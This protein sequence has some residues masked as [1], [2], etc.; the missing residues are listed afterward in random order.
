MQLPVPIRQENFL[1]PTFDQTLKAIFISGESGEMQRRG[2]VVEGVVV[3][4]G[5]V[6]DQ[7][8]EASAKKITSIVGLG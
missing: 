8:L 3:D 5:V 2:P 4:V 7:G 6:L 1:Y